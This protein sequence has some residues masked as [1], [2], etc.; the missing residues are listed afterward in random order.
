MRIL[1][2]EDDSTLAQFL[3]KGLQE[4][5]YIIDLA[6]DGQEGLL[7]ARATPY[8]LI[9]LDIR[10]PKLDGLLVCRKLRAEGITIPILLLTARQSADDKVEGLDT[11]AD[12]YL[13]KPFAYPEL[14]ARIRALLRRSSPPQPTRLRVADLELDPVS[15]KVWRAGKEIT[16]TH[17]EYAL[18]EYLMRNANRALT[19]TAIIAHVWDVNYDSMTNIVDVQIR[20][21]RA[22]IDRD[23]SPTLLQTVRGVGYMLE[24]PKEE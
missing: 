8:D 10:L 2:V 17:K 9:I 1:I 18:L 11:G 4:E 23:F 19:R 21:L 14:L 3:R 15:H 6:V 20:A 13:T 24:T 5:R 12:D 7:R 22:K 16:L